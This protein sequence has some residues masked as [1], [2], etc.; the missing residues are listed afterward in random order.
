[1]NQYKNIGEPYTMANP[2]AIIKNLPIGAKSLFI[3]AFNSVYA[4]TKDDNQARIAGWGAVKNKYKQVGDKWV[5][6]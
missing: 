3:S 1:M 6:K 5:I 2:P 4:K